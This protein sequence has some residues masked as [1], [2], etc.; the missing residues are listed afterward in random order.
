MTAA[1][2]FIAHLPQGFFPL[3]TGGELA[4]LYC[5][6]FLSLAAAGPRPRS[7]DAQRE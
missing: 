1:V 6:G 3:L 5:F 7:V 2:Y 4:T